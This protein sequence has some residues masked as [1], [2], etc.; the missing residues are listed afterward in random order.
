MLDRYWRWVAHQRQR[1]WAST[2]G[3]PAASLV[4]AAG[5]GLRSA[6]APESREELRSAGL[7]H[8]IAVSGLHIAVAALWL[9]VIARRGAALLPIPA[10]YACALAWL[11]LWGYVGLTGGAASAVRAAA[12]LTA[13]DLGTVLGRPSHGPTTL[14]VVAAAMLLVRPEWL[15]DPGFALSLS[16][17]AAIVTAPRDLGVLAASWRITWATAPL[18]VLY[19]DVAPLHGL[20]GNAVAL[21]LFGVMMPVALV[22]CV[23]P[24]AVGAVAMVVARLFASPILDLAALLA[25]VPAFG[26]LGLLGAA[27]LG[28]VLG[29]VV[30]RPRAGDGARR[31][32]LPP[33]LACVVAIA[34]SMVVLV[35]DVRERQRLVGPPSFDWIAVGTLRSRSLLVAD[36]SGPATACLYRPTDSGGT[37]RRLLELEGVRRISRLDAGLPKVGE[38]GGWSEPASDPRTRAL[39]RQLER[40]GFELAEDHSGDGCRPPG[41]AKLRAALRACRYLQGGRGRALVRSQGGALRCRIE[42]R[43]VPTSV[44]RDEPGR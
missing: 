15:V 35:E 31:G 4:V 19:F 28:L 27:V 37:W 16:A 24:G 38:G 30:G 1:A 13:V 6:L 25:R 22:A 14:A 40:A 44:A 9:Q 11:P 34:V 5:L 18:S 29:A 32:W 12:M 26:P 17:M 21:P 8:L 39:G 41:A 33:K 20:V 36:P 3:D 43:W 23:V 10:S 2:R 7:G 42:D